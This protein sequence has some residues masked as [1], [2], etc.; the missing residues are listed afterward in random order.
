MIFID[1]E[2]AR[3]SLSFLSRFCSPSASRSERSLVGDTS[4][5]M[6]LPPPAAAQK[7]KEP[8]THLDAPLEENTNLTLV[9]QEAAGVTVGRN[10]EEAISALR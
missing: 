1:I 4:L 8:K 7:Q 3:I 5:P 10:V 2:R 6:T 9:E